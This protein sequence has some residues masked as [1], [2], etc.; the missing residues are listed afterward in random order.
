MLISAASVR[1]IGWL[2]SATTHSVP[3]IGWLS[4]ATIQGVPAIGWLSSATSTVHSVH[5]VIGGPAVHLAMIDY[6][7]PYSSPE[8][9]VGF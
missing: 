3:E 2:S 9:Q 5:W 8:Y 7:Y 6:P 4:S 1:V